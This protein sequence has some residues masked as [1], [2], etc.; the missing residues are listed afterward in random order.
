MPASQHSPPGGLGRDGGPVLD[1]AASRPAVG[2]HRR[3]RRGPRFRVGPVRKCRRIARFEHP[4]GHPRQRIGAAHRARRPSDER[5]TWDVGQEYLGVFSPVRSHRLRHIGC[6]RGVG[7]TWST[8]QASQR[9]RAERCGSHRSASGWVLR[10]DRC[11]SSWPPP[12]T[13]V[14]T[15]H[16]G[17]PPAPGPSLSHP[18]AGCSSA[19]AAIAASSAPRMRAPISG[20][21]RPCSTTVPSSSCQKVKS[22]Y[23]RAAHR[24]A[25]S[26]PRAWPCDTDAR[27]S[28]RAARCRAVRC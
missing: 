10:Q 13:P 4:L 27:T 17:C 2:E 1:F 24:P 18:A 20:G 6:T 23:S 14:S 22:P 21:N 7:G 15:S 19:C 5:P 9:G 25:R 28:P 8:V 3:P 11:P 12:L 26:P 16:V